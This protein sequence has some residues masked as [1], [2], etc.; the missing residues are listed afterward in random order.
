[1]IYIFYLNTSQTDK[2]MA[3]ETVDPR[4]LSISKFN[5][6]L[7]KENLKL[8]KKS[9]FLREFLPAWISNWEKDLSFKSEGSSYSKRLVEKERLT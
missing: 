5:D 4:Q 7:I 3:A 1:M 2:H 8:S 9:H 6:L